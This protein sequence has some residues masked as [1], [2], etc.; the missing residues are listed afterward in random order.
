VTKN[1]L[2]WG[3]MLGCRDKYSTLAPIKNP[4]MRLATKVPIGKNIGGL[5]RIMLRAH[6]TQAPNTAPTPTLTKLNAVTLNLLFT[7]IWI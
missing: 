5:G 6:L 1:S 3:D 2:T 7:S 4:P